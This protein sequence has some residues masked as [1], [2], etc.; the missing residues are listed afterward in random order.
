MARGDITMEKDT[1]MKKIALGLA[2]VLLLGTAP[3]FAEDAAAGAKVN[4]GAATGAAGA[5][6]DATTTGSINANANY[7]QLVSGLRSNQD[8]DLSAFNEQSSTVNC[9]TVSSLQ[10]NAD[11]GASLEG[12]I[13]AGE[14]RL[15]ELRG[16]IQT[17]TGLWSKIQASCTNVA[18]LTVDQILWVESGAD[19]TF[20]VFVDDRN[21]AGG[22]MGTGTGAGSSTSTTSSGG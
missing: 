8:I 17:T 4:A 19:G 7:G 12:A 2:A 13:T 11:N 1:H 20:T 22:S 6:A 5:A 3:A 16:D 9:V 21:M 14:S 18:D 10:G 15:T